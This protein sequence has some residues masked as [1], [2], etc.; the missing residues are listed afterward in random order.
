[1]VDPSTGVGWN[2]A[3]LVP[4]VLKVVDSGTGSLN[5]IGFNNNS[6]REKIN[7]AFLLNFG[8]SGRFVPGLAETGVFYTRF[9]AEGG[10]FGTG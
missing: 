2:L 5:R 7:G 10:R 8:Y 6:L 9:G 3:G 4:V 1:M